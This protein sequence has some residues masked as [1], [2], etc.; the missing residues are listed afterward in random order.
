MPPKP[1][2]STFAIEGCWKDGHTWD[3]SVSRR[4]P[5]SGF[6]HP[7]T[8]PTIPLL[9]PIGIMDECAGAMGPPLA[10]SDDERGPGK[11]LEQPE[12]GLPVSSPKA[13]VPPGS[14]TGEPAAS[15]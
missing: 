6:R 13:R 4:T 10:H 2:V 11:G 15:P 5:V 9:E 3:V 7:A 14:V 12:M 8:H 1:S